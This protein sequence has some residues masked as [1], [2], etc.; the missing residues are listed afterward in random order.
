MNVFLA[1]ENDRLIDSPQRRRDCDRTR[2][3][4][5]G[6]EASF[7]FS[8]HRT[9][10]PRLAETR[11]FFSTCPNDLIRPTGDDQAPAAMR[12]TSASASVGG[13]GGANHAAISL[14]PP[15]ERCLVLSEIL[16]D[17]RERVR[18]QQRLLDHSEKLLV[19]AT[20]EPDGPLETGTPAA[21][22]SAVARGGAARDSAPTIPSDG[23]AV[24]QGSHQ[25]CGNTHTGT[26]TD[27]EGGERGAPVVGEANEQLI[28]A[29]EEVWRVS[30]LARG[31]LEEELENRDDALAAA[32]NTARES[33]EALSK[34]VGCFLHSVCPW[35]T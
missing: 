35:R 16:E 5:H 33:K 34:Q 9:T 14:T 30:E 20:R 3:A 11:L 7:S 28:A 12:L 32:A 1:G 8:V 21:A 24:G 4:Y 13:G 18:M 19:V 26:A 6:E 23:D 31:A 2:F 10:K 27:A 25:S 22:V 15:C 29:A 17:L